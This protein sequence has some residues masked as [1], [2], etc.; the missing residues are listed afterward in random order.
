VERVGNKPARR[1]CGR[2]QDVVARVVRVKGD[3]LPGEGVSSIL[4]EKGEG[5][6]KNGCADEG[7]QVPEWP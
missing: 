7:H 4:L 1:A 3:M 6:G 2:G 5:V